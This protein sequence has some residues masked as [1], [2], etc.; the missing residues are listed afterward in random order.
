MK[1]RISQQTLFIA[2]VVIIVVTTFAF[3]NYQTAVTKVSSEIAV[4]QNPYDDPQEVMQG[5][6]LADQNFPST[7][8]IGAVLAPRFVIVPHHLTAAE[9][10]ATGIKALQGQSFKKIALL[11]PDHFFQCLTLL[12]TTRGEYQTL[13]GTVESSSD[14][15]DQLL[16]SDLVSDAPELFKEEHGIFAVLPFIRYYLPTVEVTPLVY[17]ETLPWKAKREEVLDLLD[18]VIDEQTILVV[19]SDFSHYLSLDQADQQDAL[20]E[21][22]LLTSDLDGIAQLKNP[23][24]SDCPNCLWLISALAQRRGFGQPQVLLHT[25]SALILKDPNAESTTSHYAIIFE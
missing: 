7:A 14:A 6:Y 21:S 4:Y 23:D 11:S 8:E 20:T 1:R 22:V 9:T 13:F 5:I 10:I 19:S 25:N 24:Q 16:T 15:V 17:S 3:D 18:Q 2:T 12:C